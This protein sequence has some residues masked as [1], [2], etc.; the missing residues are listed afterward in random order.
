MELDSARPYSKR[1]YASN[2]DRLSNV[3]H[4]PATTVRE[5]LSGVRSAVKHFFKNLRRSLNLQ[6]GQHW[7]R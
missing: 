6:E 4:R 5:N 1:P 3:C 2:E 7:N